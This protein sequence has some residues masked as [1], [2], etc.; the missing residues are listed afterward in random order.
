MTYKQ[1]RK[2]I[3]LI[4]HKMRNVIIFIDKWNLKDELSMI[5]KTSNIDDVSD[6]E[7]SLRL[8]IDNVYDNMIQIYEKIMREKY[9]IS[10]NMNK[11]IL[12][13]S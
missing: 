1:E 7:K 6:T 13:N 8:K 5:V 4:E 10:I 2:K 12:T 9:E 11:E 3:R